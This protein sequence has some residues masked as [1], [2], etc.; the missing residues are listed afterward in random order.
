MSFII[1][2]LIICFSLRLSQPT[3]EVFIRLMLLSLVTSY[4][5]HP[6]TFL[7]FYPYYTF[8]AYSHPDSA[9][10]NMLYGKTWVLYF[11]YPVTGLL[12]CL[13]K[14]K[15]LDSPRRDILKLPYWNGQSA[16]HPKWTSQLRFFLYFGIC[17]I[18]TQKITFVNV[19]FPLIFD[20]PTLPGYLSLVQKYKK[21]STLWM[22]LRKIFIIR[23]KFQ[24]KALFFQKTSIE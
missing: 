6:K 10:S 12:H 20:P 13:A 17:E 8:Y 24:D 11:A 4:L 21:V 1:V 3:C 16:I 9:V 7:Q 18:H 23:C 15:Q 14:D 22:L 19:L 5:M 2:S